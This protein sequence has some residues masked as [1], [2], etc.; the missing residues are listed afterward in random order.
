MNELAVKE[1]NE[2]AN[3]RP[4][5]QN[6]AAV[7]LS[8]L[9]PTG[10]QGAQQSLKKVTRILTNGS[11]DWASIDWAAVRFQ[12][13]AAIRSRL[14]DEKYSPATVNHALSILRGVLRAAWQ[15]GQMSAEDY[16]RAAAVKMVHG[17]VLPA[18]REL[19][20]GE[21]AALMKASEADPGPA[22]CRDSAI[23]GLMYSCGLRREEVVTLSVNDYDQATGKLIIHGKGSKQRTAYL[24]NG[25]FYA[26]NDW[27]KLR[28][29]AQGPLFVAINK[30][31]RLITGQNMSP[32]AIYNLLAKRAEQA[33]VQ[34]FSPH[35]LRR[36]FVSDLLDAGADIAT[37]AKMAGHSSVITT[38]RYDRRPEEAKKKAAGLLSI[39]YKKG[40]GV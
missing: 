29:T 32:Q 11:D 39:P 12:H 2:L 28:G 4:L 1:R 8:S 9:Q 21:L 6:P 35:D 13:V 37:V 30:G 19:S 20:H 26:V 34:R 3:S 15:L 33:G 18:G 14:I 24:T 38:A 7:Y 17:S 25:A 5:D 40:G 10:R 36:T 27:L 16:Q 23:I 22:G 31:G